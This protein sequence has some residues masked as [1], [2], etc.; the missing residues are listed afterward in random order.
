MQRDQVV[1]AE[2]D[3]ARHALW[4]PVG[5]AVLG[6]RFETQLPLARAGLDLFAAFNRNYFV[7][8]GP[9]MRPFSYHDQDW[10]QWAADS[11]I[12]VYDPVTHAEREV[13]N[14]PCP[15]LDTITQ[16]ERGNLYF[17]NWEYSSL[18]VLAGS[19]AAACVARVTPE[20]TVDP[21]WNPDLTRLTEGRQVMNFRY[22]RDGKAI[23]AVLHAE[24][25]GAGF[26]FATELATQDAFWEAYALHYRLWL[27]DLDAGT[28]APVRGLPDGDFPPSYSHSEIEGRTFVMIEAEDFSTTTIYELSAEGEATRRFSV[29]GSSYQW[30]EV[31]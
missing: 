14:V 29:P 31:R 26:D 20:G 7:F 13:L 8:D 18:H 25:F 11:Q 30:L 2:V 6:T 28:A 19:G 9:V 23:A 3:S 24:N 1:Y 17:S 21:Q 16:D 27:F 5:F 15:G 12:V 10:F 22:L 4:D